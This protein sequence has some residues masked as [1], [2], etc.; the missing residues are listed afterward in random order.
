MIS[1]GFR[2][3]MT[4]QN[5]SIKRKLKFKVKQLWKQVFKKILF[6]LFRKKNLTAKIFLRKFFFQLFRKKIWQENFFSKNSFSLRELRFKIDFFLNS[7]AQ[8]APQCGAGRR[9]HLPGILH[10]LAFCGRLAAELC[11]GSTVASGPWSLRN[12]CVSQSDFFSSCT[13]RASGSDR[14]PVCVLF[15]VRLNFVFCKY[16]R[17]K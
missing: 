2:I 3:S 14:P 7:T 5:Q 4:V 1:N 9:W 12:S 15:V 11:E 6:Q 17:D 10:G 13:R 16:Q 8:T